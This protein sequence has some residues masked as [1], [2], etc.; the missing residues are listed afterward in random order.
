METKLTQK[1]G[2]PDKEQL[3]AVFA[4]LVTV[5][6][7]QGMG[8]EELLGIYQGEETDDKRF[9]P[10]SI[11]ATKLSPSESLCK[12]LKENL[13]LSYKEISKLLNRDERSIWTS[14][15]RAKDK[16][17]ES[18]A[19]D[20]TKKSL[21]IPIEIFSNREMSILENLVLY[22]R[23]HTDETNYGIAKIL[24]K[25]PSMIYTIYNRAKAKTRP[26]QETKPAKQVEKKKSRRL[27]I[28]NYLK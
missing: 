4:S 9:V 24:N 10:V 26:K 17:P 13:E 6:K 15:N 11:F 19:G 23:E 12:Y 14:H 27:D 28:K 21:F 16:M 25:T 8:P 22:L 18:F 2:V 20:Q 3:K 5:L 7:D 1:D